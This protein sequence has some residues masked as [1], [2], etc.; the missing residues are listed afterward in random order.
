M[1]NVPDC[2]SILVLK[3]GQVY[4]LLNLAQIVFVHEAYFIDCSFRQPLFAHVPK[5]SY[6]F[7]VI[8]KYFL[9]KSSENETYFF[10]EFIYVLVRNLRE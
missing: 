10:H 3:L 7:T 8:D 5:K 6:L 9:A 1:L 4:N 2:A